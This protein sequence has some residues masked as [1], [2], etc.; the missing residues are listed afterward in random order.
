MPFIGLV[1]VLQVVPGKVT[2]AGLDSL[3]ASVNIGIMYILQHSS[4][5]SSQLLPAYVEVPTAP[6]I[7]EPAHDTP[8]C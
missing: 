4:F 6:N 8:M 7:N 2:P 1:L 5:I 3:L